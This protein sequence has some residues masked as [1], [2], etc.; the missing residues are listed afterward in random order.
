[1]FDAVGTVIDLI[2]G[3]RDKIVE[4]IQD[5]KELGITTLKW[6]IQWG[7][8]EPQSLSEDQLKNLIF[9]R[10]DDLDAVESVIQENNME[11]IVGLYTPPGGYSGHR[12]RIFY[13]NDNAEYIR[14]FK[15]RWEYIADR[16][17]NKPY[18]VGLQLINEPQI[19]SKTVYNRTINETIALIRAKENTT[20]IYVPC[21]L[22]NPDNF[23]SLIKYDDQNVVYLF[24]YYEK[25]S[26]T[27]Q[28]IKGSRRNVKYS[29]STSAIERDLAEPLK[30]AKAN[31]VPI[32]CG[33]FGATINAA[34]QDKWTKDVLTVFGKL[35]IRALWNYINRDPKN[36]WRLN[37]K[38]KEVI[39]KANQ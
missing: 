22:V 10:L 21:P 3:D 20:P 12:P 11:V 14:V 38:T 35:K 34:E 23:K 1:M 4:Q 18:V 37:D 26:F 8:E 17:K 28:R 9:W 25:T 15:E 5:A 39:K 30:F 31:N 7:S 19:R 27:H 29:Q 32:F 6:P 16:L 36:V 2:S 33:E 24:D 13:S